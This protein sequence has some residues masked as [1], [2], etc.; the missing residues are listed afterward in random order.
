MSEK[1][2]VKVTNR[3]YGLV[4]YKI[5]D[6][7]IRREYQPGET[8]EISEEEILKLSYSSGGRKLIEKYLI[9]D[10]P[11]LVKEIFGEVEP[12]YYYTIEDVENLLLNGS[13]EQLEDCLN[14][15]DDGAIQL[16]KKKAVD[17]ELNDVAKRK[18]IFEKTGFNVDSAI[19]VNEETKEKVKEEAAPK[20]RTAPINKEKIE[21]KSKT[22]LDNKY[23]VV[24]TEE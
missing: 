24:D 19:R 4:T 17:L 23:E 21:R 15:A 6:L 16:V 7:H 8:K 12:E 3:S 5:D 22:F 13:I 9:I 10:K 2:L 14:F 20:R 1:N 18:L 11:E